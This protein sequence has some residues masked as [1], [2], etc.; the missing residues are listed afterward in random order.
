MAKPKNTPK[1]LNIQSHIGPKSDIAGKIISIN[2]KN[3][4]M[5]AIGDIK[6][7]PTRY[8]ATISHG[9]SKEYY[10]VIEKALQLGNVVLGK[11]Y[12]TPIEKDTKVLERYWDLVKT[13]GKAKNVIAAFK[14]LIRAGKDGNFSIS[15]IANYCIE[16][17]TKAR[18]RKDVIN[19]LKEVAAYEEVNELA[20]PEPYD[21]EE[22]K[23][24]VKFDPIQKVAIPKNIPPPPKDI[25]AG[26]L[27]TSQ[28][29][30]D[31]FKI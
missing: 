26:N 29:L 25:V 6:L 22:G 21:D 30:D 24:E 28:I 9:Q 23:T 14:I 3:A 31:V 10:E 12:I 11:K 7:T 1:I 2:L 19:F 15:E 20:I 5:F 27:N 13:N 17:E 4:S 8:W 16:Q 18:N